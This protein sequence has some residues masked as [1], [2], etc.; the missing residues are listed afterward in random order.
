MKSVIVKMEPGISDIISGITGLCVS[1][2]GSLL[3]DGS[4]FTFHRWIDDQLAEY[5]LGADDAVFE[6][7]VNE[8]IAKGLTITFPPEPEPIV[9]EEV[10]L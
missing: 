3:P 6:S 1:E 5:S 4:G 9:E 2:D 7:A 10:I 8:M